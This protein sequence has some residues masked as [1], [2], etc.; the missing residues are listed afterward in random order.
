MIPPA[1]V[2]DTPAIAGKLPDIFPQGSVATAVLEL[3]NNCRIVLPAVAL[4]DDH[5]YWILSPGLAV[6]FIDAGPPFLV[7]VRV[8]VGPATGVGVGVATTQPQP[9]Q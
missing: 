1:V 2:P 7:A 3:L 9:V 5:E 8:A 4:V 6:I